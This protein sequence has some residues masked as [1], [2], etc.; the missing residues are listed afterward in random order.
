MKDCRYTLPFNYSTISEDELL[1]GLV[2][3]G[4]RQ[5]NIFNNG[6]ANDIY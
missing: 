2:N 4:V 6:K 3:Y 1:E 5:L